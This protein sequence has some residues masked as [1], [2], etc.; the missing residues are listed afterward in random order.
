MGVKVTITGMRD[1]MR[2]IYLIFR[3]LAVEIHDTFQG[4][5]LEKKLTG[6]RLQR[7]NERSHGRK[8]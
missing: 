3:S 5:S 8:F 6:L 4:Q 2:R 1:N 7:E